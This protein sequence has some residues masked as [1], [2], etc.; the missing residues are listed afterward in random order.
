MP[1][2]PTLPDQPEACPLYA[3]CPYRPRRQERLT[4]ETWVHCFDCGAELLVGPLGALPPHS[5]AD[6]TRWGS[7]IADVIDGAVKP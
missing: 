7:H 1:C 2:N 3:D 5:C 6:L 4:E